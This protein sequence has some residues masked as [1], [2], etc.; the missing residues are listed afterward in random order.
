MVNNVEEFSPRKHHNEE[1]SEEEEKLFP[2]Q[3]LGGH[4]SFVLLGLAVF[5]VGRQDAVRLAG[6]D[7]NNLAGVGADNRRTVHVIKPAACR[8]AKAFDAPFFLGHG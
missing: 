8:G 5:L 2:I 3:R 6:V 7:V 4:E 1:R